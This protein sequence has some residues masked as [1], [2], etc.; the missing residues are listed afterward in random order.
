MMECRSFRPAR[1][2][3]T[4]LHGV[5]RVLTLLSNLA[6]DRSR[7]PD[8]AIRQQAP[9]T[10]LCAVPRNGHRCCQR[11]ELAHLKAILKSGLGIYMNVHS[12]N[13]DLT[14]LFMTA[15]TMTTVGVP[16][17]RQQG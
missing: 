9:V 12:S 13:A 6:G 7:T 16:G 17:S 5:T 15:G 4:H 1:K 10:P 11:C 8:A 2:L 14:T 3:Y